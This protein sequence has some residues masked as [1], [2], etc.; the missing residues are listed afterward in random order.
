M[1]LP[2]T[3]PGHENNGS[4]IVI[5]RKGFRNRRQSVVDIERTSSRALQ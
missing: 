4:L 2:L 1:T 3:G 5:D